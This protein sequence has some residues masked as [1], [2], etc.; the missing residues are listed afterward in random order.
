MDS[1]SIIL[2]SKL[3]KLLLFEVETDECLTEINIEEIGE[4]R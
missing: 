3:L 2:P 1:R 4:V